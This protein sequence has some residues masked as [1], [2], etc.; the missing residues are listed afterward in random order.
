MGFFSMLSR[1]LEDDVIM[2]ESVL[3]TSPGSKEG[4]VIE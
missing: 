3:H 4:S 1:R 2:A